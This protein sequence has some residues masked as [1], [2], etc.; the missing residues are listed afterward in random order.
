MERTGTIVSV[1]PDGGYQNQN[2][3]IHT[4][5]MTIQCADG[6]FSGQI[7]SKSQVYPLAL[8]APISVV[9]TLFNGE[10]RFK[11]F[12]PKYGAPQQT[13][14]QAPQQQPQGS[15]QAAQQPAQPNKAPQRDYNKENRGKCRHGLYCAAVQAGLDPVILNATPDILKAIEGLVEKSM[16]GIGNPLPEQPEEHYDHRDP[17]DPPF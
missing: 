5:V 6:Q 16:N 15:P 17:N 4:F 3:Y 14:Q 9:E 13:Q 10:I 8:N 12:D 1:L 2:G 7:G 11:K